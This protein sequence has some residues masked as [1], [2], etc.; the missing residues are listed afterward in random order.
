MATFTDYVSSLANYTATDAGFRIWGKAFTDMMDTMGMTQVYSNIDW[1]TVTMPVTASPTWAGKRV[2]KF[3]D[4]K[5]ATREIY[6]MLEFGRVSTS[7]A[8]IGFGI[9]VAVGTAHDGSGTVSSYVMQH[10]LAMTQAPGDGGDIIGVR[11]DM[12]FSIWTNLNGG[13]NFQG[14]F[15]VERLC[16]NGT[17]TVDG[18]VLMISGQAID[19]NATAYSALFRVANYSGGHVFAAVGAQYSGGSTRQFENVSA[20]ANTVDPSYAGK[21]PAIT[22]DTFGKYDSCWHWIMVNKL[23]YSPATEFTATINGE[24]GTYR[25]PYTGFLAD[26]GSTSTNR[27]LLALRVA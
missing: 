17:P 4:S 25:T 11:S 22:M 13:S 24:T 7:T 18:A 23:L 9:R 10:Y 16:E 15:A 27:N 5:S 3:N 8:S 1:A 14:G 6:V 26:N 21:A 2:Y 19:T 20:I 12:G